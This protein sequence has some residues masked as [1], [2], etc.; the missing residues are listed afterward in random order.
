[1]ILSKNLCTF[2]L[3]EHENL[4][5]KRKVFGHMKRVVLYARV[6]ND[7]G[8]HDT[9]RQIIELK[10]YCQQHEIEVVESFQDF[11]SA[12]IPNKDRTFL[13]KC[14]H[15]C[16]QKENNV[17][18]VVMTGISR[19]GRE[20]W[21]MM[22]HVLFFHQHHINVL[23]LHENLS[24]YNPDGTENDFFQILFAL[25]TSFEAIEGEKIK[26]RL[27]NG[28]DKFRSKGGIVGRKQGSKVSLEYME[29][30]YKPVLKEL[31]HGTSIIRTAK[32]CDVSIATVARLKTMFR[33]NYNGKK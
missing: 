6:S 15:F 4:V 18:A 10:A 26:I 27:K 22:E 33:I 20:P 21:E 3:N 25:H 11:M 31:R 30:K 29:E 2:A 14:L 1:M 28:Y 32:L 17:D 23:F 16:S 13:Q 8:R 12:T 7:G 9:E 19:L 5:K 24:L